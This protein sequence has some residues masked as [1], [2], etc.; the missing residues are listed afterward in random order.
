MR[1]HR[2]LLALVATLGLALTAGLVFGGLGCPIFLNSATNKTFPQ[3]IVKEEATVDE[4]EDLKSKKSEI[5][6]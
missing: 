6:T 4:V 5:K 3:Q 1:K 2:T